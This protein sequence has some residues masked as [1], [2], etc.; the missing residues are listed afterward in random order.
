MLANTDPS[1]IKFFI[2]WLS[3]IGADKSKI[4]FTLHLYHDMNI[5]KE[6]KFWSDTLGYPLSAFYKPYIKRTSLSALTYKN[7]F[8]HGTCNARYMSQELNDYALMGLSHIRSLYEA[9]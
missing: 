9:G 1:M 6:L 2:S 5:K 8:G 7:G 3:L 4:R